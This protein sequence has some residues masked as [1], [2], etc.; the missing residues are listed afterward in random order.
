MIECIYMDPAEY[1]WKGDKKAPDNFQVSMFS[2]FY[3]VA[4]VLLQAMR[5]VNVEHELLPMFS[6]L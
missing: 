1:N 3:N 5:Q 6:C 2:T 4:D